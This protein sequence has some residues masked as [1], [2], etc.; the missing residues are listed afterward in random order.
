MEDA[1][2]TARTQA[3]V[4]GGGMAGLLA[5]AVLAEFFARVVRSTTC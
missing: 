2:E 5:G 3:I 4:A 1:M